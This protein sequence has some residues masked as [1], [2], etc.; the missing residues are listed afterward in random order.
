[1]DGASLGEGV[2]VRVATFYQFFRVDDPAATSAVVDKHYFF[3]VIISQKCRDEHA[4]PM[5]LLSKKALVETLL[6]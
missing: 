3:A 1:V 2:A 4:E 6:V 5:T